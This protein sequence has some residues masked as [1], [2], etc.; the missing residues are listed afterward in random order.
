MQDRIGPNRVGPFGLLQ[1]LADVLK[2][3]FKEETLPR[4]A[5]KVL[6]L[7]APVLAEPWAS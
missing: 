5:D 4:K 7:L 3:L 2:F 1:V 6:F